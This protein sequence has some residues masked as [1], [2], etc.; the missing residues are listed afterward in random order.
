MSLDEVKNFEIP[1]EV[2]KRARISL[3]SSIFA[4]P[5]GSVKFSGEYTGAHMQ[6]LPT[7]SRSQ[8]QHR[9]RGRSVVC[10]R[11]KTRAL[12]SFP[13]VPSLFLRSAGISSTI[14]QS[15]SR[16]LNVWYASQAT[17]SRGRHASTLHVRIYAQ[18]VPYI[19]V[20]LYERCLT[21][22]E[23]G[24]RERKKKRSTKSLFTCGF[25]KQKYGTDLSL[26]KT[27]RA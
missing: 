14:F 15:D 2:S 18:P 11:E 20:Y 8:V 25:S 12:P 26:P 17:R 6:A 19:N 21:E 4:Y 24:K 1:A 27:S 23:E 10:A 16:P 9:H 5:R 13:H 22:E 3:T 7:Y